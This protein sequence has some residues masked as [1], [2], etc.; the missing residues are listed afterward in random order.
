MELGIGIGKCKTVGD[1]LEACEEE[2]FGCKPAFVVL[3]IFFGLDWI[4]I[5][6]L[7]RKRRIEG[8]ERNLLSRKQWDFLVQMDG[9][10]MSVLKVI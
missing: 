8:K 9:S 4:W 2:D 1:E 10:V 5:A 6:V 7:L 3:Y